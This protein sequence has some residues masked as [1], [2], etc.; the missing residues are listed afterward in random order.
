MATILITGGTGLIGKKLTKVLQK[1]KHTV[2]ILSR[3]KTKKTNYFLWNIEKQFIEEKAI[4]SAHYIIHLAGDNIGSKRWTKRRKQE[5]INSRI[6]STTLL[7]Q[8]VKELNPNLKAFISASGIGYYGAI[9]SEKI[10]TEKDKPHNDFLSKTCKLWENAST[11]FKN[12]KIRTVIF[13]TG[14]VY[15]KNGGAFSKILLPIKKGFGAVLG[16]GKQYMP[17]IHIND[18][19][20]IYLLAIENPKLKGVYNAVAPEH[21]TNKELTKTIARKAKKHIWLPNIPTLV[22]KMILGKMSDLVLYGSRI[23]SVKI[24]KTGFTFQFKHIKDCIT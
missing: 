11:P 24:Q 5:I 18:L 20:N 1:N 4:T 16:N 8:K 19:C 10:F 14:V 9:T 6:K 12:L 22:L 7:Y 21:I 23:S 2:T 3:K 15:S 17:W 13:R